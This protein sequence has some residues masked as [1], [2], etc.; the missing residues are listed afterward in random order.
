MERGAVWWAELPDPVASEPGFRRPVVIVSSNAFNWS[1][2]RTVSAVV[3]TS[4]LRLSEAPGNVF[5]A[6]AESGLPKD[7]VA[8]V[9]Q[10][11]TLDKGF[12]SGRSGC[13]PPRGMKE[14]DD[15]LRL[16]LSL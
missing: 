10:V 6:A 1:R 4:N 7:S 14:I 3:L 11:V 13:I 5:L 15:G 12:L 9:S 16:A 2:I 8:N